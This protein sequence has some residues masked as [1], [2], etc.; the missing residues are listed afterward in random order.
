MPV[1]VALL[2][3]VNVGG[4]TLKMERLRALCADLEFDRVQTYLQSGN[5]VFAT[6]LPAAKIAPL[7]ERTIAGASRL[8]ASVVV[9]TL[10]QM[11]SIIERSPFARKGGVAEERLYVT[12]LKEKPSEAALQ[13]LKLESARDRAQVL[14]TE[15]YLHVP[16]GYGETKLSNAYFEKALGV[17]ATTRN[18]KTTNALLEMAQGLS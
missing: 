17:R 9:R 4:N 3:G 7:I 15:I 10:A 5:L 1:Y 18:W 12:F 8:P 11:R 2:R 13:A 6:H 14:G 16:G